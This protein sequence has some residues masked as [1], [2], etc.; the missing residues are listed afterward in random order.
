MRTTN[1]I[2][3]IYRSIGQRH[4]QINTF[5]IGQDFDLGKEALRHP[6]LAVNPVSA[7]LPK[8][9]NGYTMYTLDF[10]VKV[11]DLLNKDKNN[12]EDVISDTLEILKDIVSEFN[13]HP[14]YYENEFNIIGDVSFTTMRGY[15]DSDVTGWECTIRV[16]SPNRR[17]FCLLPLDELDLDGDGG[18]AYEI[19]TKSGI[20]YNRPEPT[21]YN[22]SYVTGDDYYIA[23]N[24]PYPAPPEYP[25][26]IQR[27]DHTAG[28]PFLTL[29]FD[30][31]FGNKDRFTNSL[32]LTTSYDGSGG[33]I[34]DYAIDHLTGMGWRVSHYTIGAD[35]N[36][37]I[38]DVYNLTYAGF[39]DWF[40]P[41]IHQAHAIMNKS[42]IDGLNYSPFNNT[43]A[44]YSSTTYSSNVGQSLWTR[45]NHTVANLNKGIIISA[46]LYICRWHY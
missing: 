21:G 37:T 12:E 13:Q 39:S 4:Q 22:I 34:P 41:N 32:G 25:A 10:T 31:F 11:F 33:E 29:N 3:S 1:D 14:D 26:T 23:L 5:F 27:L 17:G 6:V 19:P 28:T 36:T 46:G 2:I 9:E 40:V 43:T 18:G 44:V 45:D 30:N 24:N 42:L 20:A 15:Y 7:V 16:Q 8:T 38:P 35:W